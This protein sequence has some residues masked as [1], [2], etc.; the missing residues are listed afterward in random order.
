MDF[1]QK[2]CYALLFGINCSSAQF[3]T[4]HLFVTCHA[5]RVSLTRDDAF[6]FFCDTFAFDTLVMSS[7]EENYDLD[8][9]SDNESEGYS[10]VAKKTVCL[11]S[12]LTDSSY[13]SASRHLD[14]GCT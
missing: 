4:P 12:P 10:P 8:N 6:V 9:V 13:L 14:Q 3:H 2:S 11:S 1:T 7:S 5:R